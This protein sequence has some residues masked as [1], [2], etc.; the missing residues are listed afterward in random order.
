[1]ARVALL[2]YVDSDVKALLEQRATDEDRSVSAVVRRLLAQA[3][4]KP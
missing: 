3:L 1:M 2:V 4:A